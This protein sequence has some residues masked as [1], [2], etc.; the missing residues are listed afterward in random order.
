MPR[1]I[2]S[3]ARSAIRFVIIVLSPLIE[4]RGPGP[5]DGAG[6]W[7]L[8]MKRVIVVLFAGVCAGQIAATG[9]VGWPMATLSVAIVVALPLMTALEAMPPH[10]ALELAEHVIARLGVGSTGG[11][12]AAPA[13]RAPEPS[14]WDDHRI[15]APAAR[16]A[17]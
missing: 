10:A 5:Y 3:L 6:P 12:G 1:P 15:D 2:S 11:T 8:S 4:K 16:G 9:V 17:A 13:H 14:K 7:M